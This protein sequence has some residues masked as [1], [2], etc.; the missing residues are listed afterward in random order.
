[1]KKYFCFLSSSPNPTAL[2]MYQASLYGW[3]SNQFMN[4]QITWIGPKSH[5]E[6]LD[7]SLSRFP[8]I[9]LDQLRS[10]QL[11][12]ISIPFSWRF[13]PF[14]RS[15]LFVTLTGSAVCIHYIL[16]FISSSLDFVASEEFHNIGRDLFGHQNWSPAFAEISFPQGS[17]RSFTPTPLTQDSTKYPVGQGWPTCGTSGMYSLYVWHIANWGG[18]VGTV[19]DVTDH[20][21]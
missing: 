18:T 12:M 21:K 16:Y 4:T 14:I 13:R 17:S 10:I 5:V 2:L 9:A 8:N 20:R 7:I 11:W 15:P 1:M 3:L 6:V 19:V